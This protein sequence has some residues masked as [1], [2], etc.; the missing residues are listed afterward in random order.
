[1]GAA[2]GNDPIT[3]VS[4]MK[5]HIFPISVPEFDDF[6]SCECK[7]IANETVKVEVEGDEVKIGGVVV[8]PTK[9]FIRLY[10]DSRFSVY[11]IKAGNIKPEKMSE[12][13]LSAAYSGG[14]SVS[15][16]APK[17][18]R[19]N[20]TLVGSYQELARAMRDD[21]LNGR[22]MSKFKLVAGGAGSTGVNANHHYT[23][24][25]SYM[26]YL[27]E[28]NET[29]YEKYMPWLKRNPMCVLAIMAYVGVSTYG[30]WLKYVDPDEL[31]SNA[32]EAY[33]TLLSSRPG[34]KEFKINE[35]HKTSIKNLVDLKKL[36]AAEFEKQCGAD[37]KDRL[38]YECGMFVLNMYLVYD[39]T[40]NDKATKLHEMF[41]LH[42]CT[43]EPTASFMDYEVSSFAT[44][45]V[46][47]LCRVWQFL[48][49]DELLNRQDSSKLPASVDCPPTFST[50][51]TTYDK[52]LDAFNQK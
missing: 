47:Y 43:K 40:D 39:G 4:I 26:N 25:V 31:G 33:N 2:Y 21:R 14:G 19:D 51:L 35:E 13:L 48:R 32:K 8:S 3:F 30:D 18:I 29:A 7:N 41:V 42:V 27:H 6:K 23:V 36:I 46:Q 5:R 37:Y 10:K 45:D 22:A 24:A 50:D 49:W 1:M 52:Y 15:G 9:K 20:S 44:N 28:K 11:T 34:K 38:A 17:S 16:G 12:S